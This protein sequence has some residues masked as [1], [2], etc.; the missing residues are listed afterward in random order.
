MN[1]CLLLPLLEHTPEKNC[2]D[3]REYKALY[4][5]CYDGSS[6]LQQLTTDYRIIHHTEFA[7]AKLTIHVV[8][9]AEH[10]I[11]CTA[12]TLLEC[13]HGTSCKA[14]RFVREIN[15]DKPKRTPS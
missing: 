12:A 10:K 4:S 9:L 13:L 7:L 5:L 1:I 8:P 11:G 14:D 2:Y 15:S 6:S 3:Q